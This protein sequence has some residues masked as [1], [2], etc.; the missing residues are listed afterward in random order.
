M[1]CQLKKLK[2][3]YSVTTVHV[4]Y[5]RMQLLYVYTYYRCLHVEYIFIT[6]FSLLPGL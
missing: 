1:S 6:V 3:I 2:V 4:H 5:L